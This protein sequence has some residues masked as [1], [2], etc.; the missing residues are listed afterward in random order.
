MGAMKDKEDNTKE[1][2][3]AFFLYRT[4]LYRTVL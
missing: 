1:D 4:I 3:Q 2:P